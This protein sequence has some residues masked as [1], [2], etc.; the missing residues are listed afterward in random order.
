MLDQ[1]PERTTRQCSQNTEN[2]NRGSAASNPLVISLEQ[3]LAAAI[4]DYE[5][6]C[7]GQDLRATGPLANRARR[8][9]SLL[10]MGVIVTQLSRSLTLDWP[11]L[12]M[13]KVGGRPGQGSWKWHLSNPYELPCRRHR[14][15]QTTS[16]NAKWIKPWW[17]DNTAGGFLVLVLLWRN[18]PP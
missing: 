8:F 2:T 12:C 10:R 4:A 5:E 6:D 16:N 15:M 1:I 14:H 11:A 7:S 18:G 13:S 17:L 9:A 3:Q